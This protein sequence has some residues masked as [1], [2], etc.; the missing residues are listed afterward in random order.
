MKVKCINNE[1]Y[2]F[3]QLTKEQWYTVVKE[4]ELTYSMFCD[5][6]YIDIFEKE[7]FATVK[8]IRKEKL[9]KLQNA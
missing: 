8:Q 9:E 5:I 6:G 4:N 7:C 3:F 2:Y 1:P